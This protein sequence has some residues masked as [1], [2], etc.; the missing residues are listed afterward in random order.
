MRMS[1][2]LLHLVVMCSCCARTVSPWAVGIAAEAVER[3]IGND[4]STT[5]SEPADK[6]TAHRNKGS[7]SKTHH[8]SCIVERLGMFVRYAMVSNV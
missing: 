5:Y 3:R 7:P 8:K 2:Y 4:D 6:V 1:C